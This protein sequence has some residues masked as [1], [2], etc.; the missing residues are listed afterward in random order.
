MTTAFRA[1]NI[2]LVYKFRILISLNFG[3]TNQIKIL[4]FE[5]HLKNTR[6]ELA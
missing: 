3:Q 4:F 1:Q 6:N 2:K 5:G